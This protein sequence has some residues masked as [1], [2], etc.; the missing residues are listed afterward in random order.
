MPRAHL[1]KNISINWISLVP[2]GANRRVFTA[3]GSDGYA[4]TFTCDVRKLDEEKRE[5]TGVVYPIGEVDTHGDFTTE[6]EL[7]AAMHDFAAKGR[8]AAGAAGDVNHDQQATGDYFPQVF[9][10]EAHHVGHD[11]FTAADV[12]AWAVTRKIVDDGRWEAVKSG[13]LNAFS[14]GGTALRVFDQEVSKAA[15][16][17]TIAR[18]AVA[19]L[20]GPLADQLARRELPNMIEALCEAL[21]DAYYGTNYGDE[22]PALLAVIDEATAML[23]TEKIMDKKSLLK[24]FTD[25]LAALVGG[26]ADGGIVEPAAEPGPDAAASVA[27][28]KA[29][30]EAAITALNAEHETAVAV[31]AAKI[32]ALE[33]A[34]PG[35][36]R[37]DIN[38]PP[39]GTVLGG[40]FTGHAT[41]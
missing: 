16:V 28:A 13:E 34:T 4:F 3:K 10:V 27:A 21:W 40:F 39:A 36:G 22:K 31:M 18:Q 29:E 32:E 24:S 8:T 14:F 1:L 30:H 23:N 19:V 15:A 9:K 2:A 11:G 12:G 6:P 17:S 20:K 38:N 26:F 37:A 7:D 25:S 41:A 35:T 5:V 33:K